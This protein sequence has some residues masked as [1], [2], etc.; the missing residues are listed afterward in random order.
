MLEFSVSL[1]DDLSSWVESRISQGRHANASDYV[2][3]LIRQDRERTEA[4][5][6]LQVLVQEA[7]DSGIS[8]R[9]FDE[10]IAEARAD[11]DAAER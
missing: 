3:D 4:I 2:C 6:E 10:I 8:E 5:A 11:A 9:S 7:I 1:P